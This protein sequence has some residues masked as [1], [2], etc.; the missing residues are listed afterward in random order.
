MEL[1][2]RSCLCG[3]GNTF[4]VLK[5]SKQKYSSRVCEELHKGTYGHKAWKDQ[6]SDRKKTKP[7]AIEP[8]EVS[9]EEVAAQESDSEED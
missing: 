2:I 9:L 4:K 5:T 3:C 7:R 6:L 1:E 8:E